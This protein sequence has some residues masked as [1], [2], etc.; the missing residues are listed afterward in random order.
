MERVRLFWTNLFVLLSLICLYL[1]HSNF[2]DK[3]IVI[4]SLLVCILESIY[5]LAVFKKY[6]IKPSFIFVLSFFIVNC[7]KHIDLILGRIDI[8][9]YLF[10][11]PYLINKVSLLS[12]IS[13]VVMSLGYDCFHVRGSV[14]R[15]NFRVDRSVIKIVTV[16]QIISFIIWA[17]SLRVDDLTGESYINSGSYDSNSRFY[18]EFIFVCSQ[19]MSLAFVA[20]YLGD[21]S[22]RYLFSR[23][24]KL[25]LVTSVVFVIVKLMSGDRGFAI[26]TLIMY[27]IF[28][29]MVTKI[30]VRIFLIFPVIVLG[31]LIMTGISQSRLMGGKL[32]FYEKISYALNRDNTIAYTGSSIF[33][34]T[35]ELASSIR[36]NYVALNDIIYNNNPYLLGKFHFCYILNSIPFIGSYIIDNLNID[37]KYRSSSEYV[38]ITNSGQFYSSGLG[39]NT[40]ADFYLEL[41]V[42]GV[43]VG[44]FII[45]CVLKY[46]D[47]NVL[48]RKVDEVS[49]LNVILI[50]TVSFYLFY[51]PRSYFAYWF[52]TYINVLLIFYLFKLFVLKKI[53]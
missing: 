3:Q 6:I 43:V 7:Q 31:A 19:I 2:Y 41:G 8:Y 40:I 29:L 26:F 33:F 1:F 24:P 21:I 4:I 23:F 9:D 12:A 36:P 49:I 38:T 37:K 18:Q 13:F 39:S 30:K 28:A 27:F 34:P 22:I 17:F 48:F 10:V 32:S 44:M 50:L 52:K 45:G 16:I 35:N 20:K 42:I 47:C 53:R 46:L 25:I 15:D 14:R 51:I 5:I 11:N